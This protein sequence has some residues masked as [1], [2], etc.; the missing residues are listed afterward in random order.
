MTGD[1]QATTWFEPSSTTLEM[2]GAS[3]V[4]GGTHLMAEFLATSASCPQP[5]GRLMIVSP[6]L[7]ANLVGRLAPFTEDSARS[8]DLLLITTPTAASRLAARAMS[9][10]PW[11]SCEVRALRGL[12]AKLYMLLPDKG[13]S[14]GLMG[15]HNLTAAGIFA[16]NEA[17]VL[18]Q[19][20]T[21]TS[22]DVLPGIVDHILALRERSTVIYDSKSW[23]SHF[24][25]T[26]A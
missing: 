9:S 7:D 5:G 2:S 1:C 20:H 23:P 16:N 21:P 13:A 11:R 8:L 12:H 19:G 3:I 14:V 6:F 22:L 15:S 4:F 10:L 17:G 18:V 25:S 24:D 26:A